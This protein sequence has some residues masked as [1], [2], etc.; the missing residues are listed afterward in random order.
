MPSSK[1]STDS[2]KSAL[3]GGGAR[4]NQFM[5]QLSF[6]AFAADAKAVNASQFLVTAAELPGQ[7]IGKTGT[8]YRGREIKLAGD[9]TFAPWTV[10]VINDA[11]FN[12]RRSLEKWMN[13]INGLVD[14]SGYL[15]P[16]DYQVDV[17][18]TQLDR[19]NVE[20]KSYQLY[21]CM[22]VD[23]SPIQLDFSTNDTI[24]EYT[25]TFEIQDFETDFP[26][27]SGQAQ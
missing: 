21:D 15:S 27:I 2:F 17:T 13:G 7:S 3:T 6:P 19:N 9:R 26:G 20:L 10:T 23:L 4:A 24:E 25:V 1:F 12:I 18:V 11:S 14:N 5:V 8:M 22:P 16:F